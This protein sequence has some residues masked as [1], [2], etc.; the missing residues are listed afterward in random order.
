MDEVKRPVR[1][2]FAEDVYGTPS[3]ERSDNSGI[4]EMSESSL[5]QRRAAVLPKLKDLRNGEMHGKLETERDHQAEIGDLAFTYEDADEYHN[6]LAELYAYSEMEEFGKNAH[7]YK[8]FLESSEDFNSKFGNSFVDLGRQKQLD[9]LNILCARFDSAS[10][11]ERLSAARA[12]LYVLQGA[13][14][15]Y[16][17]EE[18]LQLDNSG[19]I[20]AQNP[21]S[22]GINNDC[23]IRAAKYGYL[24]AEVGALEA[25]TM[26]LLREI[27]EPFDQEGCESKV[28]SSWQLSSTDLSD[29]SKRNKRSATLVDN[30]A[31]RTVLSAMYHLVETIRRKEL[32]DAITDTTESRE[33]L[34]SVRV[35]FL[36]DLER[37]LLYLNKPLLIVLFDMMTP[38]Y[39]GISPHFPVKKIFLLTWKIILATFGGWQAALADK[40]ALRRKAGLS[41]LE[42]TLEVARHMKACSLPDGDGPIGGFRGVRKTMPGRMLGRQM[43]YTETDGEDVNELDGSADISGS[44]TPV[45]GDEALTPISSSSSMSTEGEG[46]RTPTATSPSESR[47]IRR[48]PWSG[49]VRKDDIDVFMQHARKKFFSYELSGDIDTVFG[50]PPPILSSLKV[51]KKHLYV[52]LGEVQL[53]QEEELNRYVFSKK[54]D[55]IGNKTELIYRQLLPT[56]SN[57]VVALLKVLLAAAPSSKAKGESVNIFCDVLTPETDAIDVLSSS[58]SLDRCGINPLEES[59]RLAIDIHRHKEIVVKAASSVIILLLKHFK[60]NHVFQFEA[61]AQQLIYC[62]GI[63]LMLKFLD[64]NMIRYIQSRHEIHPYNYPQCAIYWARNKEEFPSLNADN[65]EIGPAAEGYYLWRNVFS[66][67]N[68]VRILN[69]LTKW[70]LA[71]TMMLVVFKSAP[72]LKRCLKIRVGLFQL[73]TLKLLKMQARYLGR[74]WRRSNMDIISAI[75]CTVRHRLADDWAFANDPRSK[76]WDFQTD[77]SSLKSL[78]ERFHSRRYSKIHPAF[79]IEVNENVVP[80]DNYLNHVDLREYEPV[81]NCSF[82]VLGKDMDLP[83]NFKDNY[84]LW[85]TREVFRNQIDWDQFLSEGK[86][87]RNA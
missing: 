65:V 2:N 63:P 19:N 56:M 43:A 69:K 7:A 9:V 26:M 61:F 81:D 22:S 14:M 87:D 3:T 83:D 67:I 33:H 53:K 62:N 8:A 29:H 84:E 15:D 51:L 35:S 55:V 80:G 60:L 49:K 73:Y 13:F 25:L 77:E 16:D 70:K 24:A 44:E 59:V 78:I 68:M 32:I 85:L 66:S 31:L 5:A 42:D 30:Q 36:E 52:S 75:Y 40:N 6:E 12:F 79:A 82:S 46:E 50:L 76:S 20:F 74:P 27:E 1:P 58:M 72:I 47:Q 17:E 38:F 54:E 37:P 48:L 11:E 21:S 71:R 64:Q 86:P 18:D 41:I 10:A 23:L 57:Y 34:R 4:S 45:P 39:S 28:N